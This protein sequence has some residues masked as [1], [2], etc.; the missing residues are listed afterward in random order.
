MFSKTFLLSLKSSS[1]RP[2][3]ED[4]TARLGKLTDSEGSPDSNPGMP[5]VR[6]SQEFRSSQARQRLCESA[7]DLLAEVGYERL[8]TALIAKRAE[9]S[10]GALAHHY[11]TKDDLL[12][13]AFRYLLD[14]WQAKREDFVSQHAAN[15]TMD[16]LLRYLWRDVFGRIDYVASLELML[17]ARHHPEL[18]ARLQAVLATWT[19]V[20]DKMFMQILPL[21]EPTGEL[22]TFLQLNFSVLRGLALFRIL[23]NENQ[24]EGML[25]MWIAMTSDFLAQRAKAQPPSPAPTP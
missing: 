9:V 20:R 14:R 4:S 3:S 21:D 23:E 18:R 1:H 25:Q 22:S 13:A 7:V 6:R 5:A 24:I 12:V 11:P 16:S 10:K 17:A 15:A 2:M 19:G 8:T